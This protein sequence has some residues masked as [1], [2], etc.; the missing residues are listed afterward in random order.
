[1]KYVL[2]RSTNNTIPK[3][4]PA[5]GGAS[6]IASTTNRASLSTSD[7]AGVDGLTYF[8]RALVIGSG[9]AILE[10]SNV[11]SAPKFGVGDLNQA[12]VNQGYV[13][14]NGFGGSAACFSEY[15]VQYS[16]DSDF[17][18]QVRT[19][20]VSSQ[21]TT[22]IQVPAAGGIFSPGDTIYF[23]VQVVHLGTPSLFVVAQTSGTPPSFTY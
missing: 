8:Y 14:W 16:P 1:M 13:V 19:I 7:A 2:L 18:S 10:G 6:V 20:I 5:Q 15:R 23:R 9:N 12:S 17:G 21:K 11:V 22:N 3:A 4:Y